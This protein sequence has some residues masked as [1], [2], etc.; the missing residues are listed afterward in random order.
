MAIKASSG[1]A[2]HRSSGVRQ[3]FAVLGPVAGET[4]VEVVFTEILAHQQHSDTSF[5]FH[6]LSFQQ[7]QEVIGFYPIY[8]NV[9]T[10]LYYAK[11]LTSY[12]PG[13][14]REKQNLEQRT[15]EEAL[16][17]F[18]D[19]LDNIYPLLYNTSKKEIENDREELGVLYSFLFCGRCPSH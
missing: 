8:R 4:E 2:M 18:G 14:K 10:L 15:Y 11:R 17:V 7:D 13:R 3:L 19:L 6:L 12:A 16:I 1:R 5:F 9:I